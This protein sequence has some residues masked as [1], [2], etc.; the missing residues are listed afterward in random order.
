MRRIAL[1]GNNLA[2]ALTLDLLLEAFA[3]DDILV[4][5]PPVTEARGWQRSLADHARLNGV[6]CLAPENVNDERTTR[7][8]TEHEPDLF[9]SVYYTQIF[10]G[11][12]LETIRGRALNFHPSLLPLHRGNAPL[13]W[14][15][16]NGDPITGLSVHHID[17]GIDTGPLVFQHKLPI[18]PEDT[19]YSLHRKMALLVRAT[20]A[21]LLGSC[22]LVA[23]CRPERHSRGRRVTTAFATPGSTASTGASRENGSG[24]SFVRWRHRFPARCRG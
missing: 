14:A 18:H 4:I 5:V 17:E 2:A 24:T 22:S 8:V 7:L 21:E 16:A 20:A 3:P 15:V 13:I 11:E 6:T 9:L 12:L 1:A 19:G 23:S 10:R